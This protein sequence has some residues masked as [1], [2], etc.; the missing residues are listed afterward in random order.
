[1]GLLFLAI[2]ILAT[3]LFYVFGFRYR[4]GHSP[5]YF[6]YN[7]FP[8]GGAIRGVSRYVIFLALPISIAF[9][10][11]LNRG[12]EYASRE[13]TLFR[14][15]ALTA[16]MLFLGAVS[17]FEQFGVPRIGATGFS[18]RLEKRY[19]GTL[20]AELSPDCEAFYLANGALARRTMP[21]YQYDAML[22][23]AISG[24][25][26]LNA[27]SS[28]FPTAWDLYALNSP[29]YEQKVKSWVASQGL[30]GKNMPPRNRTGNRCL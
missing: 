5:W 19:L 25:P 14:R 9:A 17:V 21:E 4:G 7:Y 24:I 10:Y 12:L 20:A 18:V 23:S 11:V 13:Q 30:K 16:L 2:L 15:R 29:E 22:I 8:G 1:L 27:S 28:Q 3:T 26:T 6:I